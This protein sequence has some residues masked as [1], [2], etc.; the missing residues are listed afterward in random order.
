MPPIP[1]QSLISFMENQ[2]TKISP[3]PESSATA[4]GIPTPFFLIP[5]F[6]TL[7]IASFSFFV[8]L[9]NTLLVEKRFLFCVLLTTSHLPCS[10]GGVTYFFRIVP[11]GLAF[12]NNANSLLTISY[13]LSFGWSA[14]LSFARATFVLLA[15]LSY[16]AMRTLRHGL[17]GDRFDRFLIFCFHT[18]W[19]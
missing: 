12:W 5:S 16:S 11:S 10:T 19:E 1:E 3:L 17:V 13:V 15:P 8:F 14:S 18:T 7:N 6:L 2:S 9:R 4:A